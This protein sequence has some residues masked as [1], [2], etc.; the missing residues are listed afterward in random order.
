M[1]LRKGYLGSDGS[2]FERSEDTS[3]CVCV[4][5]CDGPS[6]LCEWI[7]VWEGQLTCSKVTK[8]W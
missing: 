4:A 6:F 5:S 1:L 2:L 8:Y 3:S 7:D